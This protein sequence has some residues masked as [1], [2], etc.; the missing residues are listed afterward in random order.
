MPKILEN[1]KSII[2]TMS[3]ICGGICNVIILFINMFVFYE[4]ISRYIFNKPTIWV[5]ETCQYLLPVLCF[6][7]ASYCLKH[8]G[9]IKVDLLVRDF[10]IRI[11]K[12]LN[13]M[14]NLAALMFFI[15]LGWESYISW[16]E[17]YVFHFTSGT[18]I[19]IPLWIPLIVLPIGMIF[20]SL[21]LMVEI[22]DG[23]VELLK[24]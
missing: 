21:Q 4:V 12:I 19:D 7:G 17:A 23:I 14:V 5:T 10:P 13:V 20:L 2:N 15:V 11:R 6:V 1:I 16:R 24:I 9:H 8:K 3:E 18:I 22:R